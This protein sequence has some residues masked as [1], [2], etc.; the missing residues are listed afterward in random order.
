MKFHIQP[1]GSGKTTTLIRWADM[2]AHGN[3]GRY[4]VVLD[5]PRAH[6]VAQLADELKCDIHFPI[7]IQEASRPV[8]P[9]VRELAI[10]DLDDILPHLLRNHLPIAH[11]TI[12]E[13][14]Q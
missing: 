11:V 7:T 6:F 3:Q 12:T 14:I 2:N 10:D 13:E 1:R 5:H 4:I 8:G 9:G